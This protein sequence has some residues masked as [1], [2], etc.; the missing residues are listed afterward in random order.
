M[1]RRD[2]N[3]QNTMMMILRTWYYLPKKKSSFLRS[4]SLTSYSS[5]TLLHSFCLMHFDLH[6][7]ALISYMLPYTALISYMLHSTSLIFYILNPT[8]LF[9]YILH[10]NVLFYLILQLLISVQCTLTF[11]STFCTPLH[12]F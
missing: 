11:F 8:P 4:V 5:C 6:S 2:H 1:H 10:S 12:S 9:S 7:T 3:W